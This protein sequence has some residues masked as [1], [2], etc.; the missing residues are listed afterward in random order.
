MSTL[1]RQP[2]T[3]TWPGSGRRDAAPEASTSPPV[4]VWAG[5]GVLV[6]CFIAFVFIRW[7]TGPFFETVP[8]GP[9]DPPTWM[10]VGL[11]AMQIVVPAAALFILYRFAYRPW[12]RDGRPSPDGILVLAFAT[13]FFW[14][15]LSGYGGHWFTY[16]SWL[17]NFGSWANAVPGYLGFGI[18]GQQ[19]AY[20]LLLIPGAY[21]C[22]FTITAFLGTWVMR[23]AKR[24]WPRLSPVGLMAVCYPVMVAFDIV[25]E[26]VVFLPLGAWSYPGGIL[27]IFAGTYHQYPLN[28][29]LTTAALFTGWASLRYFVNDKGETIAERGVSDLRARRGPKGLTLLRFLACVGMVHTIFFVTYNLPN[30]WV[31]M[32]STPWPQ[33]VQER[34]YLTDHICGR[35]VDRA[36]PSP[37]VPLV[38][39]DNGA[40]GGGS[41]YLG[42]D[43]RLV[44]PPNTHPVPAD[45]YVR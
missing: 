6:L 12:R 10:K 4:K 18:P 22:I 13:L 32:H 40:T 38:R 36:C 42:G 28:E 3:E 23:S 26:G 16:N 44:V 25:F 31:G 20:P 30:T 41:A 14:D 19:Q 33:D 37:D 39:N 35:D 45:P 2:E 21:V 5:I 15:A 43:N 9:S 1:D 34:S 11:V 29:A 24:R 27:N 8:S 17:I 7:M